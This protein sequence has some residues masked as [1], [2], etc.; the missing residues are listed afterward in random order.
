VSRGPRG[1]LVAGTHSGCGKTS[2]C[3]GLMAAFAR[4]GLRVAPFKTGPD[5]I[6]PGLHALAA[7]RTSHNLDGWMTGRGEMAAIFSRHAGATEG[8]GCDLAVVEGAMGLF[9][10]FS[11]NSEAGSAAQAAKILNLPTLLCVSAASMGRSA[12]ALAKGYLEFDNGLSFAGIVCNNV[13]SPSHRRILEEAFESLSDTGV[14]LLGCLPQ[15][16]RLAMPSRHLGLVTAEDGPL[17]AAGISALADWVEEH[18]DLAALLDRLPGIDAVSPPATPPAPVRARI[19][20]ARDRAFCF[21]YEENLR[22]LR[23]A[24]AQL[25]PFSPLTDR[26]LPENI[27]GAYLGGGYPELHAEA[28]SDN[29]ALLADIRAFAASGGPVYAECGGFMYLMRSLTDA[30]GVARPM[31]GIFPCGAA[32]GVKRA[33]LGYREIAAT[34]ETPLGP[35]GTT[36]RG[37]EFHYSAIVPDSDCGLVPAS[38]MTGRAGALAAPGGYLAGRVYGGYVHLHFGSNPALA[39]NFVSACA[40]WK[41]A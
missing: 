34:A 28:L 37:H 41:G 11:G 32:M 31:A 18:I 20:L 21:Y 24:G 3:L 29:R 5:F 38:S 8:G 25:V 30:Q 26:A 33:A 36:A 17:G 23:E 14:P 39:E 13:K 4:N 15:D 27:D 16:D 2:L 9:D 1:L 40:D 19:A 35:A 10:G 6:D 22:R 12:A 7:G